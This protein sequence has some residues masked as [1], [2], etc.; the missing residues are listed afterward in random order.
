[1]SDNEIILSL[2]YIGICMCVGF[3]V[4]ELLIGSDDQ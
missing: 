1:M 2:L 3:L 4:F